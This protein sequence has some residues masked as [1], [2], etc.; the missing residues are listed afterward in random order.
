MNARFLFFAAFALALLTASCSSGPEPPQPGTPTFNWN[1]AKRAYATGDFT[2]ANESLSEIVKT[3]SEYAGRAR[4]WSI[5][6]S[7]GTAQGYA[8]LADAYEAGATANRAN[9][10]PFRKP[11]SALRSM[12][13]AAILDS[14]QSFRTVLDSDRG[15]SVEFAFSYP[16]G[17][18]AEPPALKRVAGG[19]PILD[20]DATVLQTT[21]MQRGVVLA[22]CRAMGNPDDSAKT[23]EAFKAPEVRVPRE[24]FLFGVAQ[25]L[26]SLADL[27]IPR[28]LDQPDRAKLIT[29]QAL[30][31]LQAIPETKE[32][33]AL[34][35]K[36]QSQGKK[37]GKAS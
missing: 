35:V 24:T 1:A 17:S 6:L 28:K 30:R 7:A 8:E 2:K 19:V 12:A 26:N 5:L 36:I 33:K 18:A 13:N 31:A 3:D 23:L 27:Y 10:M 21:M 9:P 4:T 15:A 32:S 16:T 34:M 11:I 22:V 20:T 29:D 25:M 14:V 37:K